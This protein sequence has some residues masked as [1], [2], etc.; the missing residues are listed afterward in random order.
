MK[1][2]MGWFSWIGRAVRKVGEILFG[3]RRKRSRRSRVLDVAVGSMRLHYESRHD[4]EN[5]PPEA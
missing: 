4:D 2:F 3:S 1:T 5:W